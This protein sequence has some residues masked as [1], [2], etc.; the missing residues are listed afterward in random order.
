MEYENTFKLFKETVVHPLQREIEGAFAS[1][2]D[3][4]RF[5]LNEFTINF[6]QEATI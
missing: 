3:E 2:G 1:I 4:Y 5:T 6:N